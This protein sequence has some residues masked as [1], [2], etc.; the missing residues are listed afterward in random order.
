MLVRVTTPTIAERMRAMLPVSSVNPSGDEYVGTPEPITISKVGTGCRACG[1]PLD[2]GVKAVRVR[3][4]TG[5]EKYVARKRE[6]KTYYYVHAEDC[7]FEGFVQTLRLNKTDRIRYVGN[8]SSIV[9]DR[10][11][12]IE[13]DYVRSDYCVPNESNVSVYVRLVLGELSDTGISSHAQ[14]HTHQRTAARESYAAKRRQKRGTN[15]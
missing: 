9:E 13:A 8:I 11:V 4:F 14:L 6:P 2:V 1:C 7:W 10:L 5:F 3:L 15:A 12:A